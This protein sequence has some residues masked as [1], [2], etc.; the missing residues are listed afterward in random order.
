M[1]PVLL[2]IAD[3]L[4]VVI[5]GG[6]VAERKV[7]GLLKDGAYV[8]V[9]SPELTDG[10]TTLAREGKID[11]RNK[12]FTYEDLDKA[13]LVFAATD[14]REI[15]DMIHRQARVNNQLVNVADDPES[16]DFHVP[17]AVRRGELVLTIS[18]S[19]K[20]PAV[21]A[22]IKQQL[23][24]DFGPEYGKLLELMSMVRQEISA[25]SDVL[26]QPERKKI[27]KKVLHKDI[28]EW[29]RVGRIELLRKHLRD[30]LGSETNLDLTLLQLDRS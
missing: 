20:S 27:Y 16:C 4:C 10:L 5:G 29:I 2:D 23:E 22:L 30:I 17:A 1:Y 15:Q 25:G 3:K 14:N 7:K 6:H 11:W 19:G 26:S 24:R 21:A 12:P 8:R 18:T 13:F 28:I 9:I